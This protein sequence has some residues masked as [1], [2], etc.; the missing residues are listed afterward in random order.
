MN[1][2]GLLIVMS[3]A[4]L[5]LILCA[6]IVITNEAYTSAER[7]R[8]V[9][10]FRELDETEI[11]KRRRRRVIRRER[12]RRALAESMGDLDQFDGGDF[13]DDEMDDDGELEFDDDDD[14][15]EVG[16]DGFVTNR[17]RDQ[18]DVPDVVALDDDDDVNVGGN[19]NGRGGGAGGGGVVRFHFDAVQDNNNNNGN[20]RAA[21]DNG[22][23]N[24]HQR[25]NGGPDGFGDLDDDNRPLGE[26]F[27]NGNGNNTATR[28][29]Q[30]QPQP[31]Q[32]QQQQQQQ[33]RPPRFVE[34]PPLPRRDSAQS[35]DHDMNCF[36]FFAITNRP[37]SDIAS[38]VSQNADMFM[39]TSLASGLSTDIVSTSYYSSTTTTLLNQSVANTSTTTNTTTR[40]T[41]ANTNTTTTTSTAQSHNHQPTSPTT[42]RPTSPNPAGVPLDI[43]SRVRFLHLT[44]LHFAA[45]NADP[46]HITALL[47]HGADLNAQD[48]TG[49][50]PLRHAVSSRR[51]DNVAELLRHGADDVPDH[52]GC[53]AWRYAVFRGDAD[54][55][56]AYLGVRSELVSEPVAM[57]NN[58]TESTDTSS[59]NSGDST[60]GIHPLHVAASFGDLDLIKVLIRF[61][62]DLEGRD[63]QL[64]TPLM[65]AATK[66]NVLATPHIR[67]RNVDAA[68][69]WDVTYDGKRIGKAEANAKDKHGW[70]ALH[71]AAVATKTDPSTTMRALISH[72]AT[73][74]PKEERYH[75]TP[76]HMA[77]KSGCLQAVVGLLRAGADVWSRTTDDRTALCF[78][79]YGGNMECAK[80]ILKHIFEKEAQEA[81]KT[82][83]SLPPVITTKPKTSML[84]KLFSWF[85]KSGP[86]STT[87]QQSPPTIEEAKSVFPHRLCWRSNSQHNVLVTPLHLALRGRTENVEIIRLLIESGVDASIG[88]PIDL[89]GGWTPFWLSAGNKVVAT[90]KKQENVSSSAPL[91]SASASSGTV[92]DT[93]RQNET[94]PHQEPHE[95][96]E[97]LDDGTTSSS[98]TLRY[99]GRGGNPTLR[100]Q[101]TNNTNATNKPQL[102]HVSSNNNTNTT[103]PDPKPTTTT[104]TLS[105]SSKETSQTVTITLSPICFA[106]AAGQFDV[107]MALLTSSP[108][109]QTTTKSKRWTHPINITQ[110]LL[111]L[112]LALSARRLDVAGSLIRRTRFGWFLCVVM[113]CS[114]LLSGMLFTIPTLNENLFQQ[115]SQFCQSEK[116]LC[117]LGCHQGLYTRECCIVP[118]NGKKYLTLNQLVDSGTDCWVGYMW[119]WHRRVRP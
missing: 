62:A 90:T 30:L 109:R 86:S 119:K 27:G 1:T 4:S 81:S 13:D 83:T 39:G 72:G 56:Q 69:G 67:D 5:A 8:L 68:L 91:S 59:D 85:V 111:S 73:L 99:R 43:N 98:A 53:N 66:A 35:D 29:Q 113:L 52:E 105:T 28:Q 40:T 108:S 42:T 96:E 45:M 41:T 80:I 24:T 64:R 103:Q 97:V 117:T 93:T 110:S 48:S 89:E 82:E 51:G 38:V 23:V 18:R 26:L 36:H 6:I 22:N 102:Q 77:A 11:E 115:V 10:L 112:I 78:A 33:Q 37:A 104:K 70:T 74:D 25:G 106:I 100:S 44:A 50:T 19:G 75:L 32:Q 47:T 21:N 71:Y 92:E 65:Y 2:I 46:P 3:M 60:A 31:Q 95:H 88:V 116:K 84:T 107:A 114:V 79:A 34:P 9:K 57:G 14:E 15:V 17:V 16:H 118:P 49:R 12:L 61:G 63:A 54:M 101:Q 87:T 94:G 55:V 76:L 7:H 20:R 58:N